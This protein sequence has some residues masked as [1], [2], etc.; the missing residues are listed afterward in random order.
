MLE[1]RFREL[2]ESAPVATSATS[3]ASTFAP[4]FICCPMSMMAMDPMSR[5]AEIYRVAYENAQAEVAIDRRSSRREFS[6]N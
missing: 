5:V 1:H 2:F 3:A 4:A 6:V